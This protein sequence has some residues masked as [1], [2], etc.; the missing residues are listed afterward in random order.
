MQAGIL[1]TPFSWTDVLV[2]A[3]WG[4]GG[5]LVAIRFFHWEPRQA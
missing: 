3:A 5:M 4:V 1:S 2:V